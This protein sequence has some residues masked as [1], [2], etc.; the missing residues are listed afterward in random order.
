M[1]IQASV[2]IVPF[3]E[4]AIRASGMSFPT[5]AVIQLINGSDLAPPKAGPR[6]RRGTIDGSISNGLVKFTVRAIPLP[7]AVTEF[8]QTNVSI[9]KKLGRATEAHT[10]SHSQP[11]L[12]VTEEVADTGNR[13]EETE[14]GAA[15]DDPDEM[16]NGAAGDIVRKPTVRADEFWSALGGIFSKSGS[17]WNDVCERIWSFGPFRAGPNILVDRRPGTTVH[18]CVELYF[19][20]FDVPMDR[21]T[22]SL[23]DHTARASDSRTLRDFEDSI[24]TGFQLATFQ[25]PLCAEPLAG[26]AFVVEDMSV[27]EG[28]GQNGEIFRQVSIVIFLHTWTIDS[29]H[30]DSLW[31]P[32]TGYQGSL[33]ICHARLVSTLDARHVF[34]RHPSLQ[35]VRSLLLPLMQSLSNGSAADVLGKVY[36]TVAR[37][38]GR[39]VSEEMKESTSFFTIKA[40]LPVVE[41]FGFAEGMQPSLC[42]VRGLIFTDIRKRTSGAASPQLIFG[43]CDMIVDV[44]VRELIERLRTR[45]ELYD[46]DPFW[47]PTT[48][49]E[50][51]D[52][53]EKADKENIAR[54]YMN[55]VRTRK[56]MFVEKKIVQFA[57]KQ[58]TLK[59]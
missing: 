36:A 3:R 19:C 2:P 7:E 16:P 20:M 58:R 37:R 43:G 46:Q 56:G 32:H 40:M 12:A 27:S 45:Y 34:L 48:E 25:G 55:T 29:G 8:L 17:E 9:L 52:L 10:L 59:R 5:V 31:G 47:V 57:E 39:I 53:G 41:S 28:D 1:E 13:T 33:Q 23:R 21:P 50:L 49:E 18:S 22:C 30:E 6:A 14:E 44:W 24:E 11:T 51:E 54:A 35:C 26:L 15:E 38:R 42:P 4:T